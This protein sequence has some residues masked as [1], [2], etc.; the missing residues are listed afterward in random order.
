MS[1]ND[2]LPGLQEVA[3]QDLKHAYGPATDVPRLIT[4]LA[5]P[6]QAMRDEAWSEL[7]GNLWH[8]GSIYAAT[9]RAVPFLI[10]LLEIE[11]VLE[12]HKILMYLANLFCDHS[13]LQ[14]H[15]KIGELTD[16]EFEDRLRAELVW[17]TATKTAIIAG[18]ET[19]V[20]QLYGSALQPKIAA[21]YLLGVVGDRAD[22]GERDLSIP[23]EVEKC[24]ELQANL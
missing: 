9:A 2:A 23:E 5:Q 10:R 1:W 6:N 7:Y 17:V 11:D 19:Y 20:G 24:C 22:D 3:W 18:L 14:A 13:Y 15:G 4:A 16:A 21:A 12:K 8:Q